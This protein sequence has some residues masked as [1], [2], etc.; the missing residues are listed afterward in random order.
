LAVNAI[1]PDHAWV[2]GLL[3]VI[4]AAVVAYVARV[5]VYGVPTYDRVDK[6]GGSAILS[7]GIVN[8]WY[9]AMVP[10]ARAL[11][12]IGVSA[13]TVSW[14][15]LVLGGLSGAAM[16]AGRFGLGTVLG[17]VGCLCDALDGLVARF[18]GK[19]SDAGEVLD[20]AIDR[21][22]EIFFLGGVL[23]HYRADVYVVVL[24]LATILG[25]YMISYSTAKAEAMGV[26]PP[27]G[28]MRRHER[29]AY[30]LVAAGLAS[31]SAAYVE[32]TS[33]APRGLPMILGLA[34][35]AVVAN[36]SSARRFA[37]I[38]A[39]LRARANAPASDPALASP[40]LPLPEADPR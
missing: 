34:I 13:N 15:S 27:R 16:G 8:G 10:I 30:L 2:L 19:S 35:V 23:V 33:R 6:I 36:V 29:S 11:A 20:A 40:P 26:T 32:P 22:T 28:M 18:S 17:V 4:A 14:L 9:W 3:V 39:A 12:A 24:A 21:Y 31:L 25:S 1:T 7:K 5:V 38:A 37:A